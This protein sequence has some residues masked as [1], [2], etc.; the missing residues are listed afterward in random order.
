MSQSPV[1]SRRRVLSLFAGAPMLPLASSL[2]YAGLLSA[3]G[4]DDTPAAAFKSVTFSATP[5]PTLANPAAM[6]TTYTTSVMS[7]NFDDGTKK[8]Y[9]LAYQPFF[10]TGDLV[11]STSGGS[12][13]QNR[14]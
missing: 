8:D 10:I 13:T 6:A 12:P 2:S 1:A 7:V 9:K 3:C 14:R 4:G 11:T 5:A